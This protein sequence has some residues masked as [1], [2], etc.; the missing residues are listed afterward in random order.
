MLLSKLGETYGEERIQ[1]I[2]REQPLRIESLR[3][4]TGGVPRT[5]V[6]LFEIFVDDENGDSFKDLEEDP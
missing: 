2:I 5:V 4:L 6:L 1:T 3:R